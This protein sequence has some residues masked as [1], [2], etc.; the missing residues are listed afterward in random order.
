MDTLT[1]DAVRSEHE[2][3]VF[4]RHLLDRCQDALVLFAAG[5]DGRQDAYWVNEAGVDATCVDIRTLDRMRQLYPATWEFV[6]GEAFAFARA[7]E[8]QWDLVTVDCPSGMFALC[9]EH[10]ALF[11]HLARVAVVLGN[12]LGVK[13]TPPAGWKVTEK[14]RRS[15]FRGGVYWLVLEHA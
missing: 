1:L 4:P 9:A 6:Q 11:C 14:R 8:R 5:F 13:V 12:G 2:G 3:Q 15:N 10:V 7:T